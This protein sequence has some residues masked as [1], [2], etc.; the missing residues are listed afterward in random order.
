MG[1]RARREDIDIVLLDQ[2]IGELGPHLKTEPDFRE[3]S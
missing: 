3:K 2:N 1:P